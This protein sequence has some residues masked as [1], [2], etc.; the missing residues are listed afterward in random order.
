[1]SVLPL[2]QEIEYP[3]SDGQPMAETPLHRKVMN[4]LIGGLEDRY[5]QEPDVWA[6]GNL[7]LCYEEGN[8]AACVAPDVLLAKGVPKWD[9][10]NYL[11]WEEV[12]PSLVVEITSKKTR[13]DDQGKK[14]S[15]YE[16]LGVEELVLFDPYGEYL[17]PR[18]QGYR[19]VKGH[20]QPVPL[21]QDGAFLSQT[22]GLLFHPEGKRL[23]L[24]D[25]VTGERYLWREESEAA[26]KAEAAARR[27]AQR[28]AAKEAAA[29][30]A[31][32][33]RAAEAEVKAAEEAAARQAAEEQV[34]A[35]KAE[36]D[37]LRKG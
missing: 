10:P 3:T 23:R 29:R 22:T 12:P 7:F 2:E 13:R 9:R 18:L 27:A 37:R 6:G 5:A 34:R 24:V 28:R 25:A 31:A 19:L 15:L 30:Q 36:L 20:Y 8:P 16:R 35:L 21:E 26:R 11:L 32:E 33:A 4:D 14:K 1:M 17:R